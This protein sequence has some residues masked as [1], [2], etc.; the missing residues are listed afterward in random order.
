[1]KGR[2]AEG[3]GEDVCPLHH[4]VTCRLGQEYESPF[5]AALFLGSKSIVDGVADVCNREIDTTM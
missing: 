4:A 2:Q 3:R 5:D 1:V